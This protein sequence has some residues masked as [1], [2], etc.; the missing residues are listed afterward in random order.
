MRLW[1]RNSWSPVWNI[2]N[3]KTLSVHNLV[4]VSHINLAV[5]VSSFRLQAT[6]EVT[7]A[8]MQYR[9]LSA[10]PSE[11]C[12]ELLPRSTQQSLQPLHLSVKMTTEDHFHLQV[13]RVCLFGQFF[14]CASFVTLSTR[15]NVLLVFKTCCPMQVFQGTAGLLEESVEGPIRELSAALLEVMECYISQGKM[16]AEIQ[17]LHSR[18]RDHSNTKLKCLYQRWHIRKA[19]NIFETVLQSLKITSCIHPKSQVKYY[20]I[21]LNIIVKI[22]ESWFVIVA[23]ALHSSPE[24]ISYF[25]FCSVYLECSGT[26]YDPDLDGSKMWLSSWHKKYVSG[27]QSTGA[28]QSACLFSSSLPPQCATW[29]WTRATR[30]VAEPNCLLCAKMATFLICLPCR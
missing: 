28:Q 23:S 25:C 9:L 20:C 30:Q 5:T 21:F 12:L 10:S 8:N 16:L 4:W 13:K 26:S 29:S 2:C 15:E 1:T 19:V 3:L 11:L 17:A 7:Q 22:H 14:I 24:V 18:Y 27:L 6:L